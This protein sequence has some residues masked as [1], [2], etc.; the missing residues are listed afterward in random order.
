M[1]LNAKFHFEVISP[2][3]RRTDFAICWTDSLLRLCFLIQK[4]HSSTIAFEGAAKCLVISAP[5][6][7]PIVHLIA[8]SGHA[9]KFDVSYD[10]QIW[11]ALSNVNLFSLSS[12]ALIFQEH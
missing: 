8:F 7:V 10:W 4:W 2:L 9:C 6:C 12:I 1:D 3:A 5:F 11:T